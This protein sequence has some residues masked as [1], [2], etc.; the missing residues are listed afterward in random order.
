MTLVL[1]AGGF[2]G[3][4]LVEILAAHNRNVRAQVRN[5][6]GYSGT[7]GVEYVSFD[8][9][10]RKC[11]RY[12]RGVSEVIYLVGGSSPS[13]SESNRI[14]AV[15]ISV[16]DLL[17]V[18][19]RCLEFGIHKVIFASSGG[20]VYDPAVNPKCESAYVRPVSSYGINKVACEHYLNLFN[21]SYGMANISLR[22]SNAYGPFQTGLKQQGAVAVFTKR[23]LSGR[24]I[25]IWG[26]G[27]NTRDYVHVTDIARAFLLACVHEGPESVFNIS[28]NTGTST[29]Q[30]VNMIEEISGQKA[31]LVFREMRAFD[32]KE[33]I[34]PNALAKKHLGWAPTI[35]LKEGLNQ[36][37]SWFITNRKL[38]G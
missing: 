21:R 9:T 22:I 16:I 36:T 14:E 18:L 7:N 2:I 38:W 30:L 1:G 12:Y 35:A 33:S 6:M 8:H 24:E 27:C 5:P 23:I 17:I 4:H 10:D 29:I 15:N 26:D 28:S 19:E 25:E 13:L 31:A 37:I 11:D 32:I 34:L 20:T 3:R